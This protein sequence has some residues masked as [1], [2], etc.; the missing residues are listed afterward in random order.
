MRTVTFSDPRIIQLVS[1]RF[2]ATWIN[3][4]PRFHNCEMATE[5]G[6]A[7]RK[8][9]MFS[10]RN[11]CTFLLDGEGRVLHYASGF[12][13]PERYEVELKIALDV[14]ARIRDADG[15]PYKDALKR[16]AERIRI[17]PD[18]T[19]AGFPAGTWTTSRFSRSALARFSTRVRPDPFGTRRTTVPEY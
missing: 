18:S 8:G 17:L 19:M 6:I 3:R 2:I 5:R 10:T 14:S 16:Y 9:E 1:E 15:T 7:I 13:S 4:L 12:L 11:L